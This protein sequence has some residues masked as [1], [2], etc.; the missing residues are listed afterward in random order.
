VIYE[1]NSGLADGD[2]TRKVNFKELTTLDT[3]NYLIVNEPVINIKLVLLSKDSFNVDEPSWDVANKGAAAFLRGS[4]H[5]AANIE[6]P[7]EADSIEQC[8]KLLK[9][10]RVRTVILFEKAATEFF[11]LNAELVEGITIH[12]EAIDQFEL[13]TYVNKKHAELAKKLSAAI[14]NAKENGTYQRLQSKY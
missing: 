3:S 6:Q 11:K 1:T 5:I 4:N 14:K 12:R 13:Y 8:I 10:D 7:H 9:R 2:A